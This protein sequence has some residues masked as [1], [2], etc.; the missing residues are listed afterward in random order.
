[1]G[2]IPTRSAS[3]WH[4]LNWI[5]W[6]TVGF[7][8]LMAPLPLSWLLRIGRG[9]GW[10]AYYF[11]PVRKAV[12][13]TNLRLCFP[14]KSEREIRLLALASYKSLGMGVF[15]GVEA[16]FASDER[17][18][19]CHT[20]EG[21]EHVEAAKREGRGVL[22]LS[23]HVHTLELGGRI[24]ARY[25]NGCVFFRPPNNPVFAKV[26]EDGRRRIAKRMFAF[27]DLKGAIRALRDGDFIWYAPDQGKKFKDTEV[28]P[29]FDVPAVT[30]AATG[31][32][33]QLGRAVVIPYSI[34]RTSDHGTYRA[35]LGPPMDGFEGT[36]P[37]AEANRVNRAIEAF[38]L[39][40]PEQY[41][42][43]HKR[44]KGRGEGYPDVYA[45]MS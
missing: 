5:P 34:V 19:R 2:S 4:P 15:E 44:F 8:K 40:A 30:N 6:L 41:L 32:I 11:V 13:L 38:V 37:V 17:I 26:I 12:T 35:R 39:E 9:L 27:N 43:Q 10:L 21:I 16:N 18:D 24:L 28:V 36:D 22:V 23:A 14:E 42:W 25:G 7:L 29:F 3:K 1:M 31:K 45:G 33:A 20:L